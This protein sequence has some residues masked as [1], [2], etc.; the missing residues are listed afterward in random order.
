MSDL[1]L[2]VGNAQIVALTDMNV[3]YPTPIA[4]L[5]PN[6]PEDA[7]QPYREMYPDTFS[8]AHMRLEIGCYLIRSRGKTILIDTGYGP[9]PFEYMGGVRGELMA[10]LASQKVA[11]ADVDVVFLSHLHLDHVGWNTTERDGAYSPAFPNARYLVH[12]SRPRPLPLAEGSGDGATAV[13]GCL[14]RAARR[15]G[16]SGRA[17]R[18][19]QPHRRSSQPST[20]R[21]IRRDT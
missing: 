20:R 15:R 6:V 16:R 10:D 13:H 7:W 1:N 2:T 17:G 3:A 5:W 18:R 8:G 14:R 19:C 21:G 11:P 12:Q 4:E 9:G